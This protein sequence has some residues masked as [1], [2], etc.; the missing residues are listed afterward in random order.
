[1]AEAPRPP[2]QNI[3]P[4]LSQ[5]LAGV[6]LT[7]TDG[8]AGKAMGPYA[9]QIHFV[10]A[11]QS[12]IMGAALAGGMLEHFEVFARAATVGR[13]PTTYYGKE[14]RILEYNYSN[15]RKAVE[16]TIAPGGPE[17][18]RAGIDTY[19]DEYLR[20]IGL[21][22]RERFDERFRA[23]HKRFE[24]E[25]NEDRFWNRYTPI[26]LPPSASLRDRLAAREGA[27]RE[28][29]ITKGFGQY[30]RKPL[31]SILT[32]PGGALS[33]FATD[34]LH[35]SVERLVRNLD[36]QDDPFKD[37]SMLTR[38]AQSR[39]MPIFLEQT[40]QDEM[41]PLL[42]DRSL[43]PTRLAFLESFLGAKADASSPTGFSFTK[44]ARFNDLKGTLSSRFQE[45]SKLI[46]GYNQ[47]SR[48]KSRFDKEIKRA[49]DNP[50]EWAVLLAPRLVWSFYLRKRFLVFLSAR[51]PGL[52]N[53]LFKLFKGGPS[54]L[55]KNLTY[56]AGELLG[57]MARVAGKEAFKYGGRGVVSGGRVVIRGL[58]G[59]AKSLLRAAYQVA[60]SAVLWAVEVA[61]D[62]V[63]ALVG[64]ELLAGIGIALLLIL[65][66]VVVVLAIVI[67]V[68][69][70]SGGAQSSGNGNCTISGSAPNMSSQQMLNFVSSTAAKTCVPA[71]IILAE[72]QRE[73]PKAFSWTDSEFSVYSTP[74]WEFKGATQA[75]RDRGYC[76]GNNAGA[77]GIMQ[78]LPST[79]GNSNNP[80]SYAA[81][82]GAITGHNPAD[83]CNAQ[84]SIVAGALKMKADSLTS[85]TNCNIW[86]Q[87]TVDRVA[88]NYCGDHC[89]GPCYGPNPP[90]SCGSM[91]G[92]NYCGGVY[93]F[94]LAYQSGLSC[95]AGTLGG[96]GHP[97]IAAEMEKLDSCIYWPSGCGFMVQAALT[98]A[99]YV[100]MVST[101]GGANG[102]INAAALKSST[103]DTFALPGQPA[104]LGSLAGPYSLPPQNPQVGDVVVWDGNV[105]GHT[106]IV[107]SV[108]LQGS[109][110]VVMVRSNLDCPGTY[111]YTGH[112]ETAYLLQN[113]NLTSSQLSSS[114]YHVIGVIRVKY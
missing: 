57:K 9:P 69:G 109:N 87:A 12:A 40:I 59:T 61:G 106:G 96:P 81:R 82:A 73:A 64:P 50:V 28:Q 11:D 43:D 37:I 33:D 31:A 46:R 34:R 19:R 78:F 36:A 98:N 48:I 70:A 97:K 114:V 90:S 49:A 60:K 108:F 84:D 65:V 32:N 62:V 29:Y 45:P 3:P 105:F 104:N 86:D 10:P 42:R 26:T 99:G 94:Y 1:M 39:Y 95:T 88:G 35:T 25:Q 51:F 58:G 13:T 22:S 100:P 83:V 14:D 52:S 92:V 30:T 20:D 71:A 38:S 4:S 76:F 5:V 103:Y 7:R 91:C 66:V 21:G 67:L 18:L 2:Q 102:F 111:T 68:I 16:D 54:H 55:L 110:T 6:R 101:N 75:V 72:M 93:Q 77:E 63:V 112:K 85:N 27:L 8:A 74:G 80:N 107:T 89:Q 113:G 24:V 41:L 17:H 56:E 15:L 44:R 47:A 79:F 53:V 23:W